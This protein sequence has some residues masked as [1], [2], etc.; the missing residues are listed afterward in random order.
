M[1]ADVEQGVLR[2]Q[3]QGIYIPESPHPGAR[4]NGVDVDREGVGFRQYVMM[5]L[6]RELP[7]WRNKWG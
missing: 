7:V 5:E 6:D 2:R 4:T 1:H 3:H